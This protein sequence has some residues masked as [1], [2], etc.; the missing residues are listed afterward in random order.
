MWHTTRGVNRE[1]GT[2]SG[3]DRPRRSDTHSIGQHRCFAPSKKL[4]QDGT[5]TLGEASAQSDCSPAKLV[6]ELQSRG[7]P[8]REEDREALAKGAC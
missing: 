7:I 3:D 4:Y 1:H 6:A 2:D 8:L 5:F